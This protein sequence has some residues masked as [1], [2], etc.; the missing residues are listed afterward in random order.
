[1]AHLKDVG[2]DVARLRWLLMDGRKC[3]SHLEG[4]LT[5]AMYNL[6]ACHTA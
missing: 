6:T 3:K 5:I 1:M 4:K 2:K